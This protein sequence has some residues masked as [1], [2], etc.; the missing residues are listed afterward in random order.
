[1][2]KNIIPKIFYEKMED[3]LFFFVDGLGFEV[4][5]RQWPEEN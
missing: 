5:F 3:G 4:A 1:M 2:I